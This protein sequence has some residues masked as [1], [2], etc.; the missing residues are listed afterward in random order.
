MAADDP[1]TARVGGGAA[2][3]QRPFTG[4]GA[5]PPTGAGVRRQQ[6]HHVGV[7]RMDAT[8]RGERWARM[9]R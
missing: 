2:R 8:L 9:G 6:G 3:T 5:G 7:S 1:R 4:G